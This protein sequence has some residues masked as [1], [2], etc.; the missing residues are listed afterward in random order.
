MRFAII[1]TGF[2]A[3]YYMKTLKAAASLSLAGV[4]DIDEKRLAQFCDYYSV[5]SYASLDAVLND[6]AVE[7]VVVLTTPETH[8]EIASAALAAGKHVYCEK[9]LAMDIDDARKLVAQAHSAGLVL[10]GAPANAYCD[11][12]KATQSTLHDN[13]IGKPKLVYAEMEDGAVF[14]EQWQEWRSISGA[15]WPGKHEFEIGCTL[16]HAGYSLSWLIGLFGSIKRITGMSATLFMD[17]GVDIAVGDM[18]PDFSTAILEFENGVVARLTCGLCA[19]KDRSLTIMGEDGTLTVADLW[20][21]AS[22]IFLERK[23]Q[24]LSFM[25]KVFRR[26]EAMR[27]RFMPMKPHA[28]TRLKYAH[29]KNDRLPAYPSRINFAAGIDAVRQAAQGEGKSPDQLSGE[30]LHITEAAL[31]LN[32]IAEHAGRY[33]MVSRLT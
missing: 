24:P 12:Y 16:E 6:S 18:A 2:V 14:R 13:K 23:D 27:G 19:P 11:A 20:D 7:L 22:D 32:R 17:K 31:A 4:F 26:L 30:A 8:Y 10:G 9:P 15:A 3:D 25:F 33:D 29:T 21:D 1:G 5:E 28:G